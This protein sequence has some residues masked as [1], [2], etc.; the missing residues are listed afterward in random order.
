M[1]FNSWLYVYA[2]PINLTDPSGMTPQ[3]S[4]PP[5]SPMIMQ[6]GIP[7][8]PTTPPFTPPLPLPYC[9]PIVV[10]QGLPCIPLPC[11]SLPGAGGGTPAPGNGG[12]GGSQDPVLFGIDFTPEGAWTAIHKN[13]AMAGVAA[14]GAR[15]AAI[16]G[17][18]GTAW[19]AFRNVFGITDTDKMKFEW[20]VLCEN[21]RGDKDKNYTQAIMYE[22]CK[23]A[24]GT[25]GFDDPHTV[26]EF[27]PPPKKAKPTS[28]TLNCK[29]GGA[30]THN[31]HWIEFATMSDDPVIGRNH[32]VHELGHAFN[33]RFSGNPVTGLYSAFGTDRSG[34]CPNENGVL[35][36]QQNTA[37]TQGEVWADTFLAWTFSCYT[38]SPTGRDL[39]PWMEDYMAGLITGG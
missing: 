35:K 15:F 25:Q 38:D 1:S 33:G 30:Y 9:L 32:A 20:N 13:N 16:P 11:P 8:Q 36:W 6:A 10:N 7:C 3:G 26:Y 2:N 24:D 21:C 37:D 34:L 19:S 12:G 31:S 23:N 4:L 39:Q 28:E 29:P 17:I 22:K 27:R 18:G 14:L 5:C